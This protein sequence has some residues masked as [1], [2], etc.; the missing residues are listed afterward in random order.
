MIRIVP[1][2]AYLVS[3]KGKEG[4]GCGVEEFNVP[5]FGATFAHCY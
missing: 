5:G 1:Y 2:L 3:F 4:A